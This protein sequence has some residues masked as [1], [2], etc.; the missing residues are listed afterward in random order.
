MRADD[1]EE[2]GRR[3]VAAVRDQAIR[4]ADQDLSPKGLGPVAA[5]WHAAA[6]REQA[7]D[8]VATAIPDCVD[9]VLFCL[10]NAIDQGALHLKWVRDDG[11][12]LDL[13][14]DAL[15][16]LGGWYMRSGSWRERYSKERFVDD[17]ADLTWPLSDANKPE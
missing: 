10:L 9:H 13:T 6:A 12:E 15:G 8:A 4:A 11:V 5:R 1:I 16:E 17:F 2:F 14:N 3:L 7:R